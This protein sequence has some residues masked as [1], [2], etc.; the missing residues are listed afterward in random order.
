MP[1]SIVIADDQRLFR[2]TLK[3]FLDRE[4]DFNVTGDV[5]DGQDAVSLCKKARPDIV[6]MDVAM[7]RM[8]GIAA[9]KL[10]RTMCPSTKVLMLSVH[11]DDERI[12]LALDA[13]AVGYILKDA[14]C[15]EFLEII[16][17]AHT[18][19]LILSPY[20]ANLIRGR[21]EP[22]EGDTLTERHHFTG[23]E[24]EILELLAQGCSNS[25]IAGKLYLSDQ[26]IKMY[27]KHIFR[28]L[29]VKNRTEAAIFAIKNK[30][31]KIP[32]KS[33]QQIPVCGLSNNNTDN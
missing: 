24:E 25:E 11:D 15:E 4:P 14:G 19:A 20:L 13:G 16:K 5:Q 28:K 8:D 31:A 10:I 30:M 12:Q 22:R 21:S 7:P 6:L 9:T 17:S 2:Q 26:T 1:I 27:L 32:S 23:R 33:K 29:G 3:Y 18:G